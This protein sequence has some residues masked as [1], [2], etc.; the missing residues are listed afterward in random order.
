MNKKTIYFAI[1]ILILVSACSYQKDNNEEDF[2]VEIEPI[3]E[4]YSLVGEGIIIKNYTGKRKNVKIPQY[5]QN[6]PVVSIGN[7]AFYKKEITGVTIP[8]SVKY[9]GMYAF[10]NNQL[11]DIIIPGSIIQINVYAFAGNRL[12]NIIIPDGIGIIGEG[13]FYKNQLT[14]VKFP[15]NSKKYYIGDSAFAMNRLKSVVFFDSLYSIGKNAFAWNQLTDVTIPNGIYSIEEASFAWNQLKSVTIPDSVFKI[16][17]FAF[18]SNQIVNIIIGEKIIIDVRAFGNE[19]VNYYLENGSKAGNYT[20]DNGSWKSIFIEKPK[21]DFMIDGVYEITSA[22]SHL[23]NSVFTGDSVREIETEKLGLSVN[24]NNNEVIFDDIEYHIYEGNGF[25]SGINKNDILEYEY[26]LGMF[27]GMNY[28]LF[29]ENIIGKDYS[30]KV[31][32]M[33]MKNNEI[34]YF[35][36]FADNKLIIMIN[37][38]DWDNK[39]YTETEFSRLITLRNDSFFYIAEKIME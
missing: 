20:Y 14:N 24:I 16:D 2:D 11:T 34:E 25:S 21:I 26:F 23:Y 4:A 29:D 15:G 1:F 31:K 37:A 18:S 10:A 9:I 32:A 7:K 13:A 33:T 35:L 5:L 12:T 27:A 19:F 3:Y 30:G 36:F 17:K 28:G 39:K 6:L 8:G 38:W 22:Y